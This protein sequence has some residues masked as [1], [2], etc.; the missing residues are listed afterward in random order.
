MPL[1]IP[2]GFNKVAWPFLTRFGDGKTPS[3][4]LRPALYL[5]VWTK[6]EHR[7]GD[8]VV[9]PPGTWVGLL[10]DRDHTNVDDSFVLDAK[11]FESFLTPACPTAYKIT[12]GS[13]DVDITPDLD[14]DK[15]T[16][17][18]TAAIT[19]A[20]VDITKPLGVIARPYYAGWISER[21]YNYDP[22]LIQTWVAKDMVIRVPALSA[23]EAA[24]EA[25]DLVMLDDTATPDWDPADLTNPPG[26]LKAY[27]LTASEAPLEFVVG[28][29]VRKVP[30]GKQATPSA[31]QSLSTAIGTSAPRTL[32]NFDPDYVDANVEANYGGVQGK[33]EGVPGL[34]LGGTSATIG[35]PQEMMFAKADSSGFF[36]ALDILV[37]V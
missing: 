10:N 26:R 29:C 27:G 31:G 7:D 24:I 19:T 3:Y 11:G 30:L 34:G 1:R 17:V 8:P 2:R 18:T 16:L 14:A 5:P 21:Y 33:I 20:S 37:R 23:N 9:L 35:R 13:N 25:G 4:A 22:D 12:Y 32:F 28:R 6:D 15:D 36:W